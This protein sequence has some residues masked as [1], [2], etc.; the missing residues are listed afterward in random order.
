MAKGSKAGE[1]E[2]IAEELRA[3]Y[4]GSPWHGPSVAALLEPVDYAVAAARPIGHAHT[5]WELV[6]HITAWS[7]EVARRI[8]GKP[9]GLPPEG[10][11]PVPPAPT[12]AAWKQTLERLAQVRRDLESA[13][14]AL[15]SARLDDVL[16]PVEESQETAGVTVRT[17]LYG[18]TQHDA[19]HSGQIALL[20][21]AVESREN[22]YP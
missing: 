5:I 18:L 4:D 14:R 12:P 15:A 17:M 21:R 9:P 3:G 20:R 6:L 19:Y 22:D 13:V 10:D 16:G 8:S 2:R 7:G 1:V 11:W